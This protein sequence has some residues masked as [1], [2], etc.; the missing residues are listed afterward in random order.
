M[1][2]AG[3]EKWELLS[4]HFSIWVNGEKDD[5]LEFICGFFCLIVVGNTIFGLS[6]GDKLIR[7]QLLF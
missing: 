6:K 1:E 2:V 7:A 5:E 3:S 4:H